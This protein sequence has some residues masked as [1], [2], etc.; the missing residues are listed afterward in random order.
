[1]TQTIICFVIVL[2]VAVLIS[3]FV[4]RYPFIYESFETKPNKAIKTKAT[5]NQHIK[6]NTREIPSN[7]DLEIL[8]ETVGYKDL[9]SKQSQYQ[10]IDVIQ[11]NPNKYNYDKCL[12]L[13]N[14]MQ[15][16][17]N[18]EH[19]YHEMLVHFPAY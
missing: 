10:Q 11:F 14:E 16:C 2:L 12:I 1:M 13:N 9:Y 7:F 17:N 4:S 19:T 5:T 8:A 18:D 6:T 3:S 15:L